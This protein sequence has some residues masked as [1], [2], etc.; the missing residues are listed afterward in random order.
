LFSLPV[1]RGQS[2][3]VTERGTFRSFQQNLVPDSTL[4]LGRPQMSGDSCLCCELCLPHL[5]PGQGLYFLIGL[6]PLGSLVLHPP[7]P[8][9]SH[10]S[11]PQVRCLSWLLLAV[12]GCPDIWSSIPGCPSGTSITCQDS[13]TPPVNPWRSEPENLHV[14]TA[15]SSTCPLLE[16]NL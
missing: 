9:T 11:S 1:S 4:P 6:C 16:N 13:W 15:A 14:L 12:T 3:R 8:P 5:L 2:L 7:T 10:A